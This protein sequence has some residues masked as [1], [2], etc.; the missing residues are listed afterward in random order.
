MTP[1]ALTSRET[2]RWHLA[3]LAE[4][5][6]ASVMSA[7][8]VGD[9]A[10]PY[11]NVALAD[12]PNQTERV[13]CQ[14]GGEGLGS[15]W[16]P[17][18]QSIGAVDDLDLVMSRIATVLRSVEAEQCPPQPQPATPPSSGRADSRRFA[19]TRAVPRSR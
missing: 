8:L 9:I 17:W 15:F 3:A 11:L 16:W 19:D 5:L 12:T 14:L 13:L 6:T 4:E 18:Q 10:K 7:E 2:M 1:D